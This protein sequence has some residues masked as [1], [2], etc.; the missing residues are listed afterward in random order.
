MVNVAVFMPSGAGSRVIMSTRSYHAVGWISRDDLDP[1]TRFVSVPRVRMGSV[2]YGVGGSPTCKKDI[3]V[4]AQLGDERAVIGKIAQGAFFSRV[5]PQPHGL[6]TEVVA[7]TSPE[8]WLRLEP[9]A[10]LLA[11]A[12][13]LEG[14]TVG[15]APKTRN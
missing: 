13:D 4:M 1:N 12:A 9:G 7:I 6:D 15:S 8:G 14:C 10:S 5:E 3:V 11:R 2:R